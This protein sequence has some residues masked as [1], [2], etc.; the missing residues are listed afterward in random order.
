M[1]LVFDVNSLQMSNKKWGPQ[2]VT[3]K[4]HLTPSKT[5]VCGRTVLPASTD[6]YLGV[7][8]VSPLETEVYVSKGIG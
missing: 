2:V 4:P 3:T 5:K 1:F 6:L 8:R 7:L